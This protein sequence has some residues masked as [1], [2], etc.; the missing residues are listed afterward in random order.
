MGFHWHRALRED[1][2][3]E[4]IFVSSTEVVDEVRH[5]SSRGRAL[6]NKQKSNAKR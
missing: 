2:A 3:L 1:H 6:Y 4:K 5:C